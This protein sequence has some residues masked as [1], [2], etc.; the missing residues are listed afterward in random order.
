MN[1]EEIKENLKESLKKQ[2]DLF[3]ESALYIQVSERYQNLTPVA[4]K[5]VLIAIVTFLS[6]ILI[7]TPMSYLSSSNDS[8]VEFEDRRALIQELLKVSREAQ[9]VPNIPV[10]PPLDQMRSQVEGKLQNMRVLPEQIK[11]VELSNEASDLIPASALMGSL[12]ISLAKLNL[13]QIVD[14]GHQLQIISPSVKLKDLS[15][16]ANAEDPRYFDVIYKLFSLKVPEL[17]SPVAAPDNAGRF[18]RATPNK[19]SNFRKAPEAK[20]PQ[21]NQ[22]EVEAIENED[23]DSES[24][25]E[26]EEPQD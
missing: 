15:I 25:G 11:S 18:N 21:P 9:E 2:W 16:T 23:V 5:L 10:P 8:V 24:F 7:S 17:T 22:D 6:F 20:T 3:Q 1:F 26:D 19:A 14:I 4:Q 13:R 12:N